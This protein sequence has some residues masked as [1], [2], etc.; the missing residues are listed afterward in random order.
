LGEDA[1]YFSSAGAVRDLLD[2]AV[3]EAVLRRSK[4]RN[5]DKILQ[6]YS[7]EKIIGQYEQLFIGTLS[8]NP[9]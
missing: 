4:E 9:F 8:G 6:L 1:S 3:P 2:A 7:W 5:R